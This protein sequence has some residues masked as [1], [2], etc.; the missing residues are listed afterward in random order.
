MMNRYIGKLIPEVLIFANAT[1]IICVNDHC[2]TAYST[3]DDERDLLI[4]DG[5]D[6]LPH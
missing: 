5:T 1:R 3:K 2:D 4:W 6:I